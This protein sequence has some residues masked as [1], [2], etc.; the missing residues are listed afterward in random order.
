MFENSFLYV[1]P[2]SVN[3]RFFSFF[4]IDK[5]TASFNII[6]S[7]DLIQ[8]KLF[9]ACNIQ[10]LHLVIPAGIF[11]SPKCLSNQPEMT[12]SLQSKYF[13]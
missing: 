3:I 10:H 7:I 13:T 8:R 11:P 6:R 4:I 2:F 12:S 9:Q 5:A 1:K